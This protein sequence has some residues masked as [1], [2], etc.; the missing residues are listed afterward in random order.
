MYTTNYATVS[1]VIVWR[2]GVCIPSVPSSSRCPHSSPL[3]HDNSPHPA[4]SWNALPLDPSTALDVHP[5]QASLSAPSYPL[6]RQCWRGI[7][8]NVIPRQKSAKGFALAPVPALVELAHR[9]GHRALFP[10]KRWALLDGNDGVAQL[11]PGVAE[12]TGDT[13]GET[14][15]GLDARD[16]GKGIGVRI[17]LPALIVGEVD[18]LELG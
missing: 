14:P 11:R 10:G 12:G 3:L 9:L 1:V 16:V 6:A 13:G 2:P 4:F 17:L 7:P 5:A 8:G 18:D 15:R